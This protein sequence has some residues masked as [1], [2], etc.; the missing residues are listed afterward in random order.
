[1]SHNCWKIYF[2]NLSNQ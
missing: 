2:S 1:V